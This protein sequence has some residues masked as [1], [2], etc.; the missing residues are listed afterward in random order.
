M[1]YQINLII[2]DFYLL[3]NNMDQNLPVR[4]IRGHKCAASYTRKVYT[5]DGLFK[6]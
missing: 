5:Y 1:F 2:C 4:V 3:Q 6:V